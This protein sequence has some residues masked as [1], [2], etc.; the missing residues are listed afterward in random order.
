MVSSLIDLDQFL[1]ATTPIRNTSQSRILLR[2]DSKDCDTL[3]GRTVS[4][5]TV[6]SFLRAKIKNSK[7]LNFDKLPKR[8]H[9]AFN[10][11]LGAD[12]SITPRSG[13]LL[14]Q[15]D[16]S[17]KNTIVAT[18]DVGDNYSSSNLDIRSE[19]S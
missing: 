14:Q 2:K 11:E 18:K 5:P 15:A 9:L 16:A 1:P 3:L 6:T 8:K 12:E 13:F 10:N 4:R 19:A 17:S 7:I